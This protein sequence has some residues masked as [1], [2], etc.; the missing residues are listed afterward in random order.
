MG[1]SDSGAE[2]GSSPSRRKDKPLIFGCESGLPRASAGAGRLAAV[3][4]ALLSVR[5][6][7]NP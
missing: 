1:K 4:L 3:S 5:Q 2:K 7:E 6:P